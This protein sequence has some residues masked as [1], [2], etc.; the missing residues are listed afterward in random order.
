MNVIGVSTNGFQGRMEKISL[1]PSTVLVVKAFFGT[2]K[3]RTA[4]I[5]QSIRNGTEW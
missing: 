1:H 4:F 5:Y 2:P 3:E